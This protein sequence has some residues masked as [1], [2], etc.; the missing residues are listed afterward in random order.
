V[1]TKTPEETHNA[2]EKI[3][4]GKKKLGFHRNLIKFGRNVCKAQKPLCG[5]CAL[6]DYCS[7][8]E[9][10][11]YYEI[12]QTGKENNFIILDSI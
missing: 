11:N 12:K 6:Y 1:K 3:I 2:S 5:V 7:F 4:P 10:E 8:N 9:K